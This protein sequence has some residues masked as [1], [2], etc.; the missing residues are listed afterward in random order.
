MKIVLTKHV[1]E[2][3][4]KG[5]IEPKKLKEVAKYLIETYKEQILENGYY[6]FFKSGTTAVILKRNNTYVFITFFGR[7]GWVMETNDYGTFNC[8]F[9]SKEY[10]EEKQKRKELRKSYKRKPETKEDLHNLSNYFKEKL[11]R[12]YEI[13]KINENIIKQGA[14]LFFSKSDLFV[15]ILK[16]DGV[17]LKTMTKS[18]FNRLEEMAL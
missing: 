17:R 18:A 10:L 6:K 15:E 3:R 7:T 1:K 5:N 2:R 12:T 14:Y 4:K 9:Q 16:K 8:V 13:K 11:K